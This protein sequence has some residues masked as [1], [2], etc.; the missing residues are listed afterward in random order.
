MTDD[1]MTLTERVEKSADEDLVRDMLAYP[2]ARVRT[3]VRLRHGS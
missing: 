2:R 1:R 3:P